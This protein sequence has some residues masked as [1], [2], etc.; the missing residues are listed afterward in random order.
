MGGGHVQ[1]HLPAG[2]L[3]LFHGVILTMQQGY[4]ILSHGLIVRVVIHRCPPVWF[5]LGL[6]RRGGL[7][8][9]GISNFIKNWHHWH[10]RT[11]VDTTAT[12]IA[13]AHPQRIAWG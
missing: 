10:R 8:K 3:I 6:E 2:Y 4:L 13:R 1:G 7:W 9:N 11:G 5:I 12:N